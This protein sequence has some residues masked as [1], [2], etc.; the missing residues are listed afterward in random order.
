MKTFI[1]EPIAPEALAYA[2]KHLEVVSWDDPAI[3]N[4]AECEAII[5]RAS[6]YITPE[7]LSQMPKLRIV[8]KHGVGVDNIDLPTCKKRGIRVTNT[9]RANM[10]SVA[11]LI[12][13]LIFNCTRRITQAHL[14]ALNGLEKSAPL[15]LSGYELDGRKLGLIGL[16]KIGTIVAQKLMAAFDMQ[17]TVYDPYATAKQCQ[18]L[19]IR[20]T[21]SVDELCRECDIISISVPLTKETRNM[22]DAPQLALMKPTTVLIN[23]SRGG[24]INEAALAAALKAHKIWGAA[25]DVFEHE[26]P[27]K[28]NPLFACDNFVGT[29]HS[30]ANTHDALVRMGMGAVD[31]IIRCAK[32]EA[33]LAEVKIK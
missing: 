10:N 22:I 24:I 26:P 17:V 14:A 12:M 1:F 5:V 19:G 28:D 16:G 9:P 32:G 4:Y 27:S 29:P 2:Q 25:L 13:G 8:A 11:G 30:G 23:T 6:V 33:A 15:A 21:D 3:K 31:E 7:M 20:K 18:Q